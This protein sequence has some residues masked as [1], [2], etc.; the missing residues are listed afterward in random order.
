MS[1]GAWILVLYAAA[2]STIAAV[3][4]YLEGVRRGTDAAEART[5]AAVQAERERGAQQLRHVV[6]Q[7]EAQLRFTK[8]RAQV[9]ADRC[10][11]ELL[12]QHYWGAKP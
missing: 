12:A 4:A 9:R 3:L 11:A 6:A 2:I 8:L 1:A 10:V 7:H 5:A